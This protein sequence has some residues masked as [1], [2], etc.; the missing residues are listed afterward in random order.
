MTFEAFHVIHFEVTS[1]CS[2]DLPSG[3]CRY[4]YIVQLNILTLTQR[5]SL[6]LN[7]RGNQLNAL[8]RSLNGYEI[9]VNG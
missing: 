5:H 4:M 7:G 9:F 6:Q 2:N 3:L 1:N 8:P